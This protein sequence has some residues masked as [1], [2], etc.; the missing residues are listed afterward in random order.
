[1]L[2]ESKR[3]NEFN[4]FLVVELKSDCVCVCL[5]IFECVIAPFKN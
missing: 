1:L 3:V 5:A 4:S 2:A